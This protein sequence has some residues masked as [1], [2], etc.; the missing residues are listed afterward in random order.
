LVVVCTSSGFL[1]TSY[2]FV[3]EWNGSKGTLFLGSV[4][5]EV[6]YIEIGPFCCLC[7]KTLICMAFF[8]G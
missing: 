8:D 2:S 3:S 6:L 4:T 1:V 5:Y 7:I